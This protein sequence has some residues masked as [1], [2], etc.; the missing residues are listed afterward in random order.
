MKLLR[1]LSTLRKS[2]LRLLPLLRLL[3]LRLL[4]LR[5]LL[6][7]LLLLKLLLL[8]LL[9]LKLLRSPL[10]LLR[11]PLPPPKLP[12]LRPLR[13]RSLLPL[14]HPRPRTPLLHSDYK[15]NKTI[16]YVSLIEKVPYSYFKP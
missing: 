16:N 12:Q 4:L 3:L 5:L 2:R 9:L 6:L 13:L 8:K 1:L 11:S 14:R 7:R 10:P 15:T